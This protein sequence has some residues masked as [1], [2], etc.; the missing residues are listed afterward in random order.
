MSKP[1]EFESAIQKAHKRLDDA[2]MKWLE[3]GTQQSLK[4]AVD[5]LG[6]FYDVLKLPADERWP[7]CPDTLR[8]LAPSEIA[9]NGQKRGRKD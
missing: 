9:K 4:R 3:T 7:R 1:I 5:A 8:I 2:R 6:N